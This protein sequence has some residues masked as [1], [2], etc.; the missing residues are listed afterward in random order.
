[1]DDKLKIILF[2]LGIT[3]WEDLGIKNGFYVE[4]IT[5]GPFEMVFKT[6]I[7]IVANHELGVVDARFAIL[8]SKA[9]SLV[10]SVAEIKK[11]HDL[12]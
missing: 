4:R 5:L 3:G 11:Q 7:E 2:D 9:K 1:M 6:N 8:E 12:N 10:S